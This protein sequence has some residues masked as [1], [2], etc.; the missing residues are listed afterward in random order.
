MPS[1]PVPPPTA[2]T[3]GR[4]R[5]AARAI[6]QLYDDVM[7]PSG[8]RVT[9]FSL[10]RTLARSGTARM[11]DLAAMLLLDRTA[12]SRTLEPLA[13][14]GFV[15]IAAGRDG[16]TREVTLTRAGAG[17][18]RAAEPDWRRAQARVEAKL[19]AQK[20]RTLV[21]LL[22]DMETLHPDTGDPGDPGQSPAPGRPGNKARRCARTP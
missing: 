9:Q 15:A 21:A 20:V 4:L 6:T 14:R 2:C 16:R 7:A 19:G 18:L 10:L 13:T 1:D 17:A 11:S 5:R 3:C 22:A 8:L 12:L